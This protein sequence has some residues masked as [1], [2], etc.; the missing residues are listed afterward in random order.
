MGGGA[1]REMKNLVGE[2]SIGIR[3]VPFGRGITGGGQVAFLIGGTHDDG[4]RESEYASAHQVLGL[5]R[6]AQD[7]VD[8]RVP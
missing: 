2:E 1:L 4:S 5:Q 3:Q 8:L 7:D 6:T